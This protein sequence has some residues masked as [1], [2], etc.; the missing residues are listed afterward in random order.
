MREQPKFNLAIIRSQQHITLI[1]NEGAADAHAFFAADRDILQI[2]IGGRKPPG[3]G[4]RHLI[5]CMHALISWI[6]LRGEPFNIGGFQL[7]QLAPFQHLA[8]QFHPLNAEFFQH[9]CIS[10]IGAG[11][12]LAAAR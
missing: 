9:R 4:D 1:G 11:L 10:R 7:G 8:G 2:G 12:A 6:D 3:G 5:A